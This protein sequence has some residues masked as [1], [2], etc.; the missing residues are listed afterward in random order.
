MDRNSPWPYNPK[1]PREYQRSI[2]GASQNQWWIGDWCNGST[3]DSGSVS[4]GSN[5]R[6][7]AH[8]GLAN[9]GVARPSSFSQHQSVQNPN[10]IP[11]LLKTVPQPNKKPPDDRGC[12]GSVG[13]ALR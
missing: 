3:T 7:P 8:E 4:L 13:S 5:P 9:T 12:W 1:T 6:S 11:T 2:S 10:K